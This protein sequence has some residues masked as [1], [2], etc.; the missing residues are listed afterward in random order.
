MTAVLEAKFVTFE[1]MID[2]RLAIEFRDENVRCFAVC[3]LDDEGALA[4]QNEMATLMAQP[5][6]RTKN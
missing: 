3:H 5:D 1:R 4:A 2:G 6:P